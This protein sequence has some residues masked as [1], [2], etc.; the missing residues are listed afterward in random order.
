MFMGGR[1]KRV[2]NILR[3]FLILF[4]PGQKWLSHKAK[5]QWALRK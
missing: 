2:R 3:Y 5:S 1:E 4:L